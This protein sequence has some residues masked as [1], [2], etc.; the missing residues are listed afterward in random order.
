MARITV[1]DPTAPPREVDDDAGPDAG[2]LAGRV[3]GIRYDLTW[4]SF[5]WA[6]DEWAAAFRR[7]GAEVRTWC[8]GARVGEHAEQTAKE[9]DAF[10]TDVDLAVV[11]LGN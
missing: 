5:H 3:V 7:D 2:S 8:A 4:R 9:L 11:G 6:M 1:L 10:A